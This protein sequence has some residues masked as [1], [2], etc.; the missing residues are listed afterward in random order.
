MAFRK[1][2]FADFSS[3]APPSTVDGLL[4]VEPNEAGF[5]ERFEKQ[6]ACGSVS[7][8]Y[9]PGDHQNSW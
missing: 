4:V 8:P 7:I 3:F 1:D 2:H 5:Q 6:L 9:P